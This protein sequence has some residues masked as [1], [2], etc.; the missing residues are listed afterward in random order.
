M[1][2]RG[3]YASHSSI[4]GERQ[5][6]FATRLLLT[7]YGG[8]VPITALSAGTPK[9]SVSDTAYSWREDMDVTGNAKLTVGVN[10]VATTLT[11]DDSQTWIPNSII[12]NQVTQ[13]R[14]YVVSVVGNTVEVVRGFQS[15]TPAAITTAHPLQQVSTAFGEATR[16]AQAVTTRGESRTSYVQIFKRSHE[17]TGTAMAVKLLTGSAETQNAQKAAMYLADDIENAA[18]MGRPSVSIVTTVDGPTEVRTTTGLLYAID[19]FGGKVV[20]PAAN[21]VSGRLNIKI[22]NDFIRSIFERNIKGQPNERITYTGNGMLSMIQEMVLDMKGYQ[23]FAGEST[24]GIEIT[25]LVT[26]FGKL[27]LST[28]PLFNQNP[29]WTNDMVVMHPGGM[30]RR[31]LRGM[32]VTPIGQ[33]NQPGARDA[34]AGHMLTELGFQWGGMPCFGRITGALTAGGIPALPFA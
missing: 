25:Q 23:I 14:M 2:I 13:E 8:M 34:K 20:T 7:G 18:L 33:E 19:T 29:I 1:A 10:N 27:K 21:G 11:V 4:V 28:H 17:I 5:G 3:I 24:Y 30:S 31:E 26:P 6:D 15:T 32:T 22:M 16:G 12:L 9:S